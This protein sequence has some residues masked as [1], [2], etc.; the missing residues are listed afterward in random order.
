MEGKAHVLF[1]LHLGVYFILTG[2][3]WIDLWL[4]LLFILLGLF[5]FALY[6]TR[7]YPIW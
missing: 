2:N 6:K 3:L 7:D 1:K 4:V 5:G